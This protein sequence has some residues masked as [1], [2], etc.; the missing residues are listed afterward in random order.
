M[1]SSFGAVITL[2]PPE[3]IEGLIAVPI[4][5]APEE[6]DQMASLQFD[7]DYDAADMYVT[8]VES[9]TCASQAGK[10]VV[11]SP[12]ADNTVRVI[13]AG[14][15]QDTLEEGIVA[16]VYLQ[17]VDDGSTASA[18]ELGAVVVSD[19]IGNAIESTYENLTG[20]AS[21]DGE[22]Q[23]SDSASDYAS[24]QISAN[25]RLTASAEKSL[26]NAVPGSGGNWLSDDE[27]GE[28]ID[29]SHGTEDAVV[30]DPSKANPGGYSPRIHV[31]VPGEPTKQ[32]APTT[33]T[34]KDRR[35]FSGH[36]M[37]APVSEAE[38][39]DL[40]D[41]A[42]MASDKAKAQMIDQAKTNAAML[43]P[44]EKVQAGVVFQEADHGDAGVRLI[45]SA[46][47]SDTLWFLLSAFVILAVMV[48]QRLLIGGAGK[49]R[50]VKMR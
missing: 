22:S 10:D 29:R 23:P 31:Y 33:S 47:V 21:A 16:T 27:P 13:V 48:A 14:M 25:Q 4:H 18:M 38:N 35:Y 39:I 40:S 1:P 42:V 12:M 20:E 49:S 34:S 26:D 3:T 37:T 28:R 43:V 19:P 15:N 41:E 7:F 11:F 32:V 6:G 44:P 8:S 24:G 9:G 50:N 17:R 36:R 45:S 46:H 30:R 2:Q 5:I